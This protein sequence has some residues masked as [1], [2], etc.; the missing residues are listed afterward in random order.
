[1]RRSTEGVLGMPNLGSPRDTRL[2]AYEP[3]F[4]IRTLAPLLTDERRKRLELVIERRLSSVMI[5]LDAPYDPHNG[6][7]VLRSCEAFGVR[8]L[9]VV[10][11]EG[12]PFAVARSV[13][14]GAEKWVDVVCHQTPDTFL[15]AARLSS[16]RLV[17]A[18]ANGELLP[19]DLVRIPR[20]ALVLGNERGGI[21]Q[22]LAAACAQ[23]VRVPMRGF[24]ESLNLSVSAA[25]LLHAATAGRPGD[26]DEDER[27]RLYA[28]GLYLSF[29]R[30]DDIL[31][32]S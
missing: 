22:E 9:H 13:A 30:A 3:E 29:E 24:A 16:M 21:R 25:I 26:L 4:V 2:A 12:T 6:A 31:A 11:R 23:S 19:K 10:E 17:A 14:R 1:M 27:I 32:S 18:H 5:G 28:R 15:A 8:E 20:L 7:A